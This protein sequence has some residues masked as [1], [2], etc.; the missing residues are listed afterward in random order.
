MSDTIA[1]IATPPGSGAIAL[2]RISGPEAIAVA[3]Q[4]FQ[5]S[6]SPSQMQSRHT[7]FGVVVDGSEIID[8]VLL[9]VFRA[10][11]SYTG[12]DLVEVSGHGGALI[13]ARL[14]EAVL[15]AGAR[16]ARPGEFTQRAYLH[17]KMDLTQAEAVMDLITAQTR[18]A[19]RAALE[20]RSGRLGQEIEKIKQKLLTIVAHLEA[21]FDFPEDDIDPEQEEL[22]RARMEACRDY[23]LK[24]LGTAE[25]GRLLREGISLALC[26]APNAGKSSLLNKLL[27]V[28]R[29]IVSPIAGTTRDTIE[30]QATLGGFPFRVIDTA[31]I[32]LT[33]DPVEHEGVLR[34][35]RVAETAD[36][37][38]HLVDATQVE[39]FIPPIT[40]EELLVFNKVDLIEN[41]LALQQRYPSALLIS[42]ATGEGIETLI[43]TLIERLVGK[44][45]TYIEAAPSPLAINT[46]HQVCLKRA[47]DAIERALS[48]V[49]THAPLELLAIELHASLQAVGEV[50]GEVHC[51]EI[52]GEIFSTFCIGK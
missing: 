28:E 24:L 15:Q 16:L 18:H 12:E 44:K 48:L 32:R 3:D 52:L 26:G 5:G 41:R 35:H 21:S 19:Q 6:T 36:H 42:C 9:T 11:K 14:L 22:L 7:Y 49:V 29:A 34:A 39:E 33:E 17:G 1:A 2:L 31:G 50:T 13:V 40:S 20:Q 37:S 43:E 45:A 38:L 4:I 10:P 23:L 25:E 30:E 47:L 46:R 27:G 8:E 51:E